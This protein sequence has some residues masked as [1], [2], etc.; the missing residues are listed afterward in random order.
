M[1]YSGM[2]A[3][4]VPPQQMVLWI[5][6]LGGGPV[7][8]GMEVSV[9]ADGQPGCR[10]AKRT[11]ADDPEPRPPSGVSAKGWQPTCGP[12]SRRPL[13]CIRCGGCSTAV[14]PPRH[15]FAWRPGRGPDGRR[16]I[17]PGREEPLPRFAARFRCSVH[18]LHAPHNAPLDII[19]VLHNPFCPRSEKKIFYICHFQVLKFQYELTQ[20]LYDVL[21]WPSQ[22]LLRRRER[23]R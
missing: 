16:A 22:S 14:L 17:R 13:V 21:F 10:L 12:A 2:I 9:E 7:R 6:R 4:V 3:K 20:L 11:A 23:S 18:D 19:I 15:W 5:L 8:P 1:I